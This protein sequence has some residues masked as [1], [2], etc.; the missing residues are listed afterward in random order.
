MP[1]INYP[2]RIKRETDRIRKVADALPKGQAHR[3]LN[4]AGRIDMNARRTRDT[5]PVR[6]HFEI[7]DFDL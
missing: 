6:L 2:L 1:S 5:G 4:A 7:G 3:L